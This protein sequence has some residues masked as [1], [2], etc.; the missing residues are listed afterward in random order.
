MI[1][2]AFCQRRDKKQPNWLDGLANLGVNKRL[3]E[4]PEMPGYN[5]VCVIYEWR[6]LFRSGSFAPA[7]NLNFNGKHSINTRA[8]YRRIS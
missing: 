3:N 8:R 6:P 4:E 2:M 7:I 1:N 5:I